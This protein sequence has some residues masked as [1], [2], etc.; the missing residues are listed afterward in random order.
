MTKNDIIK[1]FT[2]SVEDPMWADHYEGSKKIGRE[3]L[4]II[5]DSD[6]EIL[7]LITTISALQ[8]LIHRKRTCVE[9]KKLLDKIL[10]SKS[11]D[12]KVL[13]GM[14]DYKILLGKK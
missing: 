4:A 8:E 11:E 10:E 12:P 5:E 1:K 9:Y 3:I 7:Q 13:K 6:K 2:L 14:A